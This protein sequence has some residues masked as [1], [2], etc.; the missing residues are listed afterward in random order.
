[1]TKNKFICKFMFGCWAK[2]VLLAPDINLC[3]IEYGLVDAPS[4]HE[5]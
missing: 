5:N 4:D 3:G 2:T 1:M